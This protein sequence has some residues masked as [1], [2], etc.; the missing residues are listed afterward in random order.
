[1]QRIQQVA[2]WHTLGTNGGLVLEACAAQTF[3][4]TRPS[5]LLIARLMLVL[6]KVRPVGFRRAQSDASVGDSTWEAGC[7]CRTSD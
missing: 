1:M 2:A 3:M 6:V 7:H 4:L 5:G